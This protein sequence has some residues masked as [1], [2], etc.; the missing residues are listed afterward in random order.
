MALPVPQQR[1]TPEEYLAQERAAEVKSEYIAGQIYA[2]GGASRAHSLVNGNLFWVLTSQLRDR[3]CELHVNDMRVKVSSAGLY[4]YPDMVVVC[5]EAQLEDAHGDT[6]LNPTLI[7]EV[8]TPSTEAYD[9][10]AKFAY[11]RQLPSLREYLLVAQDRV[12]LDHFVRDDAGWLFTSTT[13]PTA[14]VTLPAIGCTLPIAEVYHKVAVAAEP[15]VP[16]AETG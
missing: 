16:P 4:T 11:Y 15:S 1:V 10:G 14:V 2:M 5:G 9:R 3:A 7:I 13:D 8:L 6:L 12:L